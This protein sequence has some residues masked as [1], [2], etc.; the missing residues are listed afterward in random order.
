MGHFSYSCHLSGLPITS[1]IKCAILP[2]LPKSNFY[3]FGEE[4]LKEFGKSC[5]I[6]ND[7]PN[8]FFNELSFP[9]FG[10]Y[11][12]YG[13]IEEIIKD[14]N[15]K[16]LEEYFD[17]TIEQICQVLCDGRK[18]EFPQ[19]GQFCASTKILK[20]DNARHM[21]LLR[22]SVVWY[23]AGF[24]EN[25]S[26]TPSSRWKDDLDLGVPGLLEEL[27]F[28]Y[29]KDRKGAKD[30]NEERYNQI[31]KKDGLE[32]H[33]DGNWINIPKEQIYSLNALKTYCKKHGVDIEID[34]LN[35]MSLEEQVY[36]CILL[37]LDSLSSDEDRWTTERVIRLLLGDPMRI[38]RHKKTDT[39]MELYITNMRIK[40]MEEGKEDPIQQTG[41]IKVTLQY[42]KDLSIKLKEKV[43]KEKKNSI[44]KTL[45]EFY[46]ETIKATGN[47][48]LKTNIADWHRVKS[49]YYSTGRY[50]SIIGTSAQD[51]DREGVKAV[52]ESALTALNQDMKEREDYE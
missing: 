21:M 52:L 17:L 6:S 38:G 40:V 5:F 2:I 4:R 32:I 42:L 9:I 43:T 44:G 8:V 50:L 14:D 46:F 22:A 31:F 15:T 39:D 48:F 27:G 11:D 33:S 30:S 7:G 34:A 51:G 3:D 49:F 37:K 20:K 25:L 1:G 19:G 24:Y 13:G 10:E 35:K 18:D 45:A 26:K 41:S 23:H 36:H 47:G 12:D 28:K 16:C 29:V